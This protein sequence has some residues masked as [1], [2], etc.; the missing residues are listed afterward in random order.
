M[1]DFSDLVQKAFYLGVGLA[2]YAG[3]KASGTLGDLRGQAQKLLDELVERGEITAEEA[4]QRVNEMM[5]R[6]QQAA[7]NA[8][9]QAQSSPQ[10]P[11]RIEILDDA[12]TDNAA[13]SASSEQKQADE[14]RRQVE[15]LR[16]ELRRLK[17]N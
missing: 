2:S 12:A 5:N 8:S 4:Q 14:L 16:D 13:A 1:A 9:T 15:A 10:E 7:G 11:R 3:E 17:D 6:A